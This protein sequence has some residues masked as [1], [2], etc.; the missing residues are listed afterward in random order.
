MGL[1]VNTVGI[2]LVLSCTAA[3]SPNDF[4]LN[5]PDPSTP[6]QG[7]LYSIS[8]DNDPTTAK[9]VT[10]RDER[11]R[12]LLGEL[13]YVFSPRSAAP[14]ETLGHSGFH[15]GLLWSG[16]LIS[17]D[18]VFW[19]V[20]EEGQRSRN[21]NPMLQT[22]QLDVRKGLPLSF[23]IGTNF[24]WLV[25][26]EMFAPGVEL[27]WAVHEGYHLAPDLGLRGSVNHV[28]GNRDLS[29]TVVGLDVVIS[30]SF[31]VA[32]MVNIAPYVSYSLMMLAAS[33]RVMDATA[34]DA[35]DKADLKLQG[36]QLT[37]NTEQKL[38]IGTRFLFSIFNISIQGEFEFLPET[39]AGVKAF[40]SV[41]TITTKLGLNY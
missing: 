15:V 32:G 31:G 10:A 19:L 14:A 41:A 23:E 11:Y 12:A 25:E 29:L 21:P 37:E 22:L 18:E 16:T 24:M 28:V 35:T 34:T 36:L 3:A 33:S 7:I 39:S 9:I 1:R 17:D 40:G 13:A 8:D 4:R 30:R 26:S 6:G 27:R 2:L 20:T 5:A 38:T